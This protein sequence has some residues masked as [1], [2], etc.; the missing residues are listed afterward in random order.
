MNT[1]IISSFICGEAAVEKTANITNPH[2]LRKNNLDTVAKVIEYRK[3][4]NTRA[5]RN[6]R[7]QVKCIS[8]NQPIELWINRMDL[9]FV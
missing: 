4:T 9:K 8:N 2:I 6:Y 5:K 1:N 7:V 3:D